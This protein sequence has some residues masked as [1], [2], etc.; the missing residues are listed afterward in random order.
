MSIPDVMVLDGCHHCKTHDTKE[1]MSVDILTKGIWSNF[2]R[3]FDLVL[4][5]MRMDSFDLKTDKIQ[6]T[7]I[8]FPI[9]NETVSDK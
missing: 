8:F 1:A 7:R 3:I 5:P 9:S 2:H 4:H 6:R